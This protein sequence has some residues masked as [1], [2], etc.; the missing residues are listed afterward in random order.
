MDKIPKDES[1]KRLKNI[2]K[3]VDNDLISFMD[4]ELKAKETI[5]VNYSCYECGYESSMVHFK[6]DDLMNYCDQC[7]NMSFGE[8]KSLMDIESII[9]FG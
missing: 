1:L 3:A 7:D 5:T 8:K 9:K 2:T 4:I 6:G